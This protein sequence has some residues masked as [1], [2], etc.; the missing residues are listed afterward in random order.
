MNPE[1]VN[2]HYCDDLSTQP[3]P[4][5]TRVL[6]TGANGYVASRLIPELVARGYI[7]RCMFRNNRCPPILKH[8]RIEVVYADCLVRDELATALEGVHTA[9]YLIHS[10]RSK[11]SGGL[12]NY[13]ST[14]GLN[15]CC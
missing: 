5:G 8:T 1:K 7:V 4:S 12:R 13:I 2:Y 6:V 11:N 14:R 3:L 10:M 9:Y 15:I